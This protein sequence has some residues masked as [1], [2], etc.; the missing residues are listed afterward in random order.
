MGLLVKTRTPVPPSRVPV[1]VFP[2]VGDC[3][4]AETLELSGD[5]LMRD[6]LSDRNGVPLR[7]Q[8]E[9]FG[10]GVFL[11]R[12]FSFWF[13]L[14]GLWHMG[15]IPPINRRLIRGVNPPLILS[16]QFG[17]TAPFT[18]RAVLI[19]LGLIPHHAAGEDHP[20]RRPAEHAAPLKLGKRRRDSLQWR[21][22]QRGQLLDRRHHPLDQKVPIWLRLVHQ[23]Q[24]VGPQAAR[25][26]AA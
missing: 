26:Q 14:S 12:S 6:A 2:V 24:H 3:P 1:G 18:V 10:E 21:A 11:A 22:G 5:T 15:F 19:G 8:H 23:R 9:S 25:L 20:V 7:R 4:G 16:L 17:I 13:F